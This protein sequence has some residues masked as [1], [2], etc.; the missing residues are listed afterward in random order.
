MRRCRY[1]VHSSKEPANGPRGKGSRKGNLVARADSACD[2]SLRAVAGPA[3]RPPVVVATRLN[4]WLRAYY[5]R[6]ER[7]AI[8]ALRDGGR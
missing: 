2:L 1:H 7:P 4:P 3:Q 5:Q 6:F 8:R